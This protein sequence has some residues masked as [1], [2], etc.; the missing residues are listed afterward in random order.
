MSATQVQRPA[1]V[2]LKAENVE[3]CARKDSFIARAGREDITPRHVINRHR[4]I[5]AFRGGVAGRDGRMADG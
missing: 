1:G 5:F 3:A 2:R 4:A